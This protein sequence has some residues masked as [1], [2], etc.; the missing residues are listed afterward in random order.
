MR[1]SKNAGQVSVGLNSLGPVFLSACSLLV[2]LSRQTVE[3]LSDPDQ[4]MLR[5]LGSVHVKGKASSVE[6]YECYDADPAELV[7]HKRAT[8]ERFIN[9]VAAFESG[10]S[11]AALQAFTAIVAANEKDGPGAYFLERCSEQI[12]AI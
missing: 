8:R 12:A 4:F 10:G 5:S 1:I 11:A 6:I 3:K 2:L 9:A 7:L